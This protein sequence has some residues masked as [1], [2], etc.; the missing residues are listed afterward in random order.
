M[1]EVFRTGEHFFG[2]MGDHIGLPLHDYDPA[3][4]YQADHAVP[5]EKFSTELLQKQPL[6]LSSNI[7]K[8]SRL[9]YTWLLQRRMIHGLRL[10]PIWI[11][12]IMS[13]YLCLT[14]S[15]QSIHLIMVNCMCV[16][17]LASF[18]RRPEE[19]RQHLAEYYSMITHMDEQIGRIVQT[20]NQT[21]QREQTI[22]VYT[23]DH[24]IA[25]GQ[26]GLMGKQ[27]LYDHSIHIPLI[28]QGP[29][30]PQGAVA[31][32][33]GCQMDIFPTLCELTGTSLPQTVEGRSMVRMIAGEETESRKSVFAAYKMFSAW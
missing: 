11:F 6:I 9:F 25:L 8:K 4:N 20:L 16:M 24:G 23:A 33:L 14:I 12:M 17:K 22:I 26:H 13:K 18:P 15:C 30:L 1:P 32:G 3:G 28:M 29:G 27:S 31:S 21:N 19:I 2:G 10:R 7:K 5:S